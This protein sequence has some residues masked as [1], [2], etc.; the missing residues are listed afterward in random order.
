M[1]NRMTRRFLS[2]YGAVVMTGLLLGGWGLWAQAQEAETLP[3]T[4]TV[5]A[6]VSENSEQAGVLEAVRSLT[7]DPQVAGETEPLSLQALV[8]QTETSDLEYRISLEKV[9]ETSVKQQ[10]VENKRILFFF[11]YFDAAFLEGSAES[12]VMASSVHAESV[13]QKALLENLSA[14]YALM[15]AVMH[16]Y[17]VYQSIDQAR[18]QLAINEN[19]FH[20]GEATS[21]EVMQTKT[22][23]VKLFQD[24]LS[25]RVTYK[26]AS[27]GLSQQ[28]NRDLQPWIY[29]AD[30]TFEDR[31]FEIPLLTIFKDTP[32]APDKLDAAMAVRLALEHR[33]ELKELRFRTM[34]LENLYKASSFKFD[35]VQ[36][37]ILESTLKQMVLKAEKTQRLI[38]MVSR[39]A[40]E[41]YELA[42]KKIQLAQ[43]QKAIAEKA[44]GQTLISHE[45]GFSSNKDVLDA[46]VSASQAQVNYANALIDYNLSQLQLL[47]EMG[48]INTETLLAGRLPL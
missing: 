8:K 42:Q 41:E 33:P 43:Q 37:R 25:T 34:S 20:S 6:K 2:R 23:L 39:K 35:K 48:L 28:L 47:Y 30:L 44:L 24:Y 26:A 22:Q 38:Q 18:Q 17:V 12:D 40:F 13:L 5:A 3:L 32:E 45:A 7:W 36:E 9:Y 4:T 14:Y 1:K 29:P 11:K 31:S 27:M 16:Q 46:Q 19:H 10:D 21:F 15:R